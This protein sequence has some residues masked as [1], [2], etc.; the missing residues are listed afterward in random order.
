[1][2]AIATTKLP[3]GSSIPVFG[4]GTWGMGETRARFDAEVA[5]LR[6]GLDLGVS[7][8]D[9]AE[10]YGN[11]GAERVVAEAISGPADEFTILVATIPERI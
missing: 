8:I 7:L 11:G 3:D 6:I 1:M 2:T 4:L 5:A 9:T 10:M